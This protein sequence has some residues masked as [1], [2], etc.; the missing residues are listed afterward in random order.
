MH[1]N[2]VCH[3]E[4]SEESMGSHI[5]PSTIMSRLFL[6]AG[7]LLLAITPSRAASEHAA[8]IAPNAIDPQALIPPAPAADSLV[9]HAEIEVLL[10]LQSTRTADDVAFAQKVQGETVFIFGADVLGNWFNATNLPKTA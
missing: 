10:H 6:L 9:Q 5:H 7:F 3:S 2:L 4:R 8:F 1:P